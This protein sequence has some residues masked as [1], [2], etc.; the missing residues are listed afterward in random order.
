[1]NDNHFP[2]TLTGDPDH[3]EKQAAAI[4]RIL[5]RPQ[6][7]A[8]VTNRMIGTPYG[9]PPNGWHERHRDAVIAP[10]SDKEMPLVFMLRGWAEYADQHARRYESK[11]GDDGVLGPAWESIGDAMRGL[12]NGET[13]RLDCGTLDGFILDTMRANGVETG[14][15]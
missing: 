2:I 7:A 11:I 4:A 9:A 15:K 12:L 6:G 3:K 14:N 5:R 1:M 8:T 13:G 10:A